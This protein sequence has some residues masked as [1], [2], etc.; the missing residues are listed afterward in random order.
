MIRHKDATYGECES[1]S[2]APIPR[3]AAAD[4][5]AAVLA[6]TRVWTDKGEACCLKPVVGEGARGFRVLDPISKLS[7]SLFDWP[8]NRLS[9]THFERILQDLDHIPR[10]LISD[11]LPGLETSV[12]VASV[13]GEPIA[14][15]L[16]EKRSGSVQAIVSNPEIEKCIWQISQHFQLHGCWNAQFK[17]SHEGLPYLLEMNPRLAAGSLH[18]GELGVNFPA[19]AVAIALGLNLAPISSPTSG[20]LHRQ[21]FVTSLPQ[22]DR[23]HECPSEA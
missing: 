8:S 5:P 2:L 23:I 10:T 3:W 4:S 1:R 9:V 6:A 21:E 19:I 14:C 17:N 20:Y 7:D 16:R 18:T 22:G 11:F 13:S 15:V 12:D